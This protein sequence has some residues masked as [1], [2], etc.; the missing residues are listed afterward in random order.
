MIL[1]PARPEKSEDD[2][3]PSAGR[4]GITAGDAGGGSSD[5]SSRG[6]SASTIGS[7][8]SIVSTVCR[9][10]WPIQPLSTTIRRIATLV[11]SFASRSDERS[12]GTECVSTG[13]SRGAQD[14]E[15]K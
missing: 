2:E 12:G 5:G 9:S 4:I 3:G 14:H 6:G 1:G 13:R 10:V 11:P 7:A 8:A 15:K